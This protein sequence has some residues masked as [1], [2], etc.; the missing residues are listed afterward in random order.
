[1]KAP[2]WFLI[3]GSLLL[4]NVAAVLTSGWW[5]YVDADEPQVAAKGSQQSSEPL[6][7]IAPIAPA[8]EDSIET[9]ARAL[10]PPVTPAVTT[11][12]TNVESANPLDRI[13]VPESLPEI[14]SL[15][16]AEALKNDPGFQEFSRLFSK[17][18]ESWEADYP[19]SAKT[20]SI[21]Q[22]AA[23]FEALDG[24][25]ETV[26]QLCSAARHI[27]GEAARYA[28]SGRAKESEAFVQMATQLRDM[29]AQLLVSEL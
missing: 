22:S 4:I 3:G 10:T 29:A 25:L 18:E 9:A 8:S 11:A 24:R 13:P 17:V 26:E 14:P 20:K 21:A 23:Y 1:M 15:D 16:D 7:T 5:Q 12:G 6:A 19:T 28:G 2:R 27:A